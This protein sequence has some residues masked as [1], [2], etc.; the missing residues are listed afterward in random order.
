MATSLRFIVEYQVRVPEIH[1]FLQVLLLLLF[2]NMTMPVPIV[3]QIQHKHVK[4]TQRD[5]DQFSHVVRWR[6]SRILATKIWHGKNGHVPLWV[7]LF[8]CFLF[9]CFVFVVVVVGFLLFFC[10]LSGEFE[11]SYLLNLHKT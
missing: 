9:V 8:V 2:F 11:V 4:R 10:V 6:V 3:V 7:L 5:S 1:C